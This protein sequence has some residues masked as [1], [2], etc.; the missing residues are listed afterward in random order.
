MEFG[1]KSHSLGTE[2]SDVKS[3]SQ[4]TTTQKIKTVTEAASG[5][6]RQSEQA[7]AQCQTPIPRRQAFQV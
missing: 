6:S 5:S 3:H 1:L 4:Q 7:L 2:M